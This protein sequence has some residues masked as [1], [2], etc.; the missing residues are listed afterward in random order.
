MGPVFFL[1]SADDFPLLILVTVAADNEPL[2]DEPKPAK[3]ADS[4]SES[5][6]DETLA[7]KTV[8]KI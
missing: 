2:A 1:D 4:D 5:S 7:E 3:P 8:I 6:D